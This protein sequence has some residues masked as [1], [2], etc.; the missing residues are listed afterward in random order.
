M[1]S[2]HSLQVMGRIP[3]RVDKHQARGADE[4]QTDTTSLG[5]QQEDDCSERVPE[6]THDMPIRT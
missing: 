3:I 5:A 4:V 6:R 2:C 1:N